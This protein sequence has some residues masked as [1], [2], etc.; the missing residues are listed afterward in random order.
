MP[1]ESRSRMISFRLTHD[2]YERFRGLCVSSGLRNVSELVR[3][4]VNRMIDDSTENSLQALRLRVTSLESHISDLTDS[5]QQA[6]QR[7]ARDSGSHQERA[8]R[9][10]PAGG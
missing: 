2:E 4:A 1:I 6:K 10:Q 5:V 8:R 3:H 7:L 9:M